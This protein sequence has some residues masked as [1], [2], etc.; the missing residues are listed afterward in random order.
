MKIYKSLRIALLVIVMGLSSCHD[1]DQGPAYPDLTSFMDRFEQEAKLLGYDFDLSKIQIAYV[2]D[3]QKNKR[4]YCGWGYSNYDGNGLKRIEISKLSGCDFAARSNTEQ[5]NLLFHE[6]GHAFFLREHE[7][8][9]QCDGSPLSIMSSTANGWT[10]YGDSAKEKR[11]YYISQLIDPLAELNKC[12][13][14]GTNFSTDPLLY[15]FTKEDY[16]LWEFGS[17]P[18]KFSGGLRDDSKLFIASEAASNVGENGY[19]FKQFNG[20][21]VPECSEVK[22]KV[23]MNSDM[24]TGPGAAISVRIYDAT[25]G[26]EGSTVN[27]FLSFTS[28]NNPVS[29][30]LD[31]HME[32]LTIPCYTR[33]TV[34]VIVF[35]VMLGGTEGTVNFDQIQVEVNP[36]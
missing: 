33:K 24:L 3:I 16:L 35:V 21:N 20:L 14:Y 23:R 7:E 29:G 10:F 28:E 11:T 15:A 31:N 9:K 8:T 2:D 26:Q 25:L 12:I 30:Q 36:K 6:I 1:D 4:S 18:A 27:E 5:E 19:W 22:F 34:Y 17:P 32:E 13:D